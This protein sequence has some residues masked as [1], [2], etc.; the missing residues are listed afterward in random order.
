M[1][2]YL[3]AC[4]QGLLLFTFATATVAK[5]SGRHGLRLFA[6]SLTETE[7]VPA[8]TALSAAAGVVAAE[9]TTAGLLLLPT[10]RGLGFGA[11]VLVLT[12]LTV[13]ILRVL[14]RRASAVCRC[15]GTT[16]RR[17]GPRHVVRNVVL[18]AVAIVGFATTSISASRT[19]DVHYLALVTG[20]ALALPLI[21]LDDVIELARPPRPLQGQ[22]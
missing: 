5:L 9:A 22:R 17:L 10:T 20:V 7:L 16:P 3:A 4:C 8:R 12:T 1:A 15:F 6:D 2:A 19:L 18:I 11:A 14:K 21:M 13:G